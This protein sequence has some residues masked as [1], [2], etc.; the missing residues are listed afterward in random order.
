MD[1]WWWIEGVGQMLMDGHC[2]RTLVDRRG[3]MNGTGRL[4]LDK[5]MLDRCRMN[6][7]CD[8]GQTWTTMVRDVTI[9]NMA[10][11]NATNVLL[12]IA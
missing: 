1:G 10:D 11:G 4:E 3:W 7:N 5:R 2:R 9:D 12:Q 8:V 6:V